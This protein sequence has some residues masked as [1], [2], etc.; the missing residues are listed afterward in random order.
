MRG[1][2]ALEGNLLTRL[3]RGGLPGNA[4]GLVGLLV[5]LVLLFSILLPGRFA[6]FGT[7]QSTMFQLP[8][9]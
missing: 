9:L 4:G 2:A 8:E 7:L 3:T 6:T 1:A 5:A